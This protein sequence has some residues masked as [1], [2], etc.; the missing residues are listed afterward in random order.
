[1]AHVTNL[2]VSLWH[3]NAQIKA[4]VP[5]TAVSQIQCRLGT[6][7]ACHPLLPIHKCIFLCNVSLQHTKCVG[8]LKLTAP[9]CSGVLTSMSAFVMDTVQY[10]KP[11]VQQPKLACTVVFHRVKL[12][13]FLHTLFIC[14]LFVC[15]LFQSIHF[16]HGLS[17]SL[18]SGPER[19]IVQNT[20]TSVLC[21]I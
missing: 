13:S 9:S 17:G 12:S 4:S 14:L 6:F 5:C 19:H 21:C 18:C 16:P 2:N 3:K 15:L 11:P 8:N 1:M 10:H 7:A 20:P